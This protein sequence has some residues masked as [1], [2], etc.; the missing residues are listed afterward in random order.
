MTADLGH[1][2]LT[3]RI[4]DK[5]ANAAI[6]V[7]IIADVFLGVLHK[8]DPPNWGYGPWRN[9]FKGRP[10]VGRGQLQQVFG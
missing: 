5:T 2:S 1:C 3:F 10:D 4:A 7:E 9:F 6:V 8:R